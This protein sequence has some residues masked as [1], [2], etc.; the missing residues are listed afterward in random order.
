M[1]PMNAAWTENNSAIFITLFV[2]LWMI[3]W[4]ALEPTEGPAAPTNVA[5]APAVG[6]QFGQ[7]CGGIVAGHAAQLATR[8]PYAC[9]LK[10]ATRQSRKP[11]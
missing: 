11:T 1:T 2:K 10:S 8:S 4:K 6:S 3:G 5:R 9:R 7:H